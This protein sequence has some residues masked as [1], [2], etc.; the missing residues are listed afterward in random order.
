M[1]VKALHGLFKYPVESGIYEDFLRTFVGPEAYI[2]FT[3]DKTL[4][5]AG[6]A[7]A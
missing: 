7:I 1:V 5:L 4:N 6:K 2:L 3:I